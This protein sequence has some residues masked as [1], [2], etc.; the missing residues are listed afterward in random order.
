MLIRE[1]MAED[2]TLVVPQYKDLD[3]AFLL[4]DVVRG[5][6]LLRALAL[7]LLTLGAQQGFTFEEESIF[8]IPC[9]RREVT[10]PPFPFLRTAKRSSISKN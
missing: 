10:T 7:L 9:R 4:A 8:S 3:A 5:I 1:I 2:P 6:C